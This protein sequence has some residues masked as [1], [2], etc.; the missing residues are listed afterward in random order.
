[1]DFMRNPSDSVVQPPSEVAHAL[2]SAPDLVPL[3]DCDI[4]NPSPRATS[5]AMFSELLSPLSATAT[6]RPMPCSAFMPSRTGTIV[7]PSCVLP[8]N[9]RWEMGTPSESCSIPSCT[10]G[11]GLRSLE[12]PRALRPSGPSGSHS[13]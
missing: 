4:T 1:M 7:L 10:I 8:R 9:A 3:S 5:A 12:T 13:K 2:S 6:T 11:F